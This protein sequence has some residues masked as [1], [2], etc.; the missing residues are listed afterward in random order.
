VKSRVVAVAVIVA[1][2]TV[3]ATFLLADPVGAHTPGPRR[4]CQLLKQGDSKRVFGSS[5]MSSE[6]GKS[7]PNAHSECLFTPNSDNKGSLVVDVSWNRK[8]LGLYRLI[9][10]GKAARIPTTTPTGAA[11]GTTIAVPHYSTLTV[12]GES[13]HWLPNPPSVGSQDYPATYNPNLISEKNGYVVGLHSL[14]MTK[15]EDKLAMAAILN[16]L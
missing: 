7:L 3:G 5:A 11:T 12:A 14:Y 6:S 10:G 15:N 8:T 2:G 1:L 16:R 9:Y 4:A 13:A